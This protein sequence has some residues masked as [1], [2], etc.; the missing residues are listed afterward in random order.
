MQLL[1]DFSTVPIWIQ[2][3][4]MISD[5]IRQFLQTDEILR[6]CEGVGRLL[7]RQPGD[8]IIIANKDNSTLGYH[9]Y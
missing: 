5:D 4:I 7:L 6:R 8:T 3:K 9:N 2:E 1:T